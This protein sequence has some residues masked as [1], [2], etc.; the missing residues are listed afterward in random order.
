MPVIFGYQVQLP[1]RCPICEDE[2]VV[3]GA[4]QPFAVDK[5]G[6]VYCRRHGLL[7][8]RKYSARI[9]EYERMRTARRRAL[10]DARARGVV[11]DE[12]EIQGIIDEWKRADSA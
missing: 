7:A 9:E 11:F 12:D 5:Q 10:A 3:A 2:I 4:S 1:A 8:S 6:Q